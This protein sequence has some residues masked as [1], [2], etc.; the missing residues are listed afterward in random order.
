MGKIDPGPGSVVLVVGASSGIGRACAER[1]HRIGYRVYGTSRRASSPGAGVGQTSGGYAGGMEMIPMDVDDEDSVTLGVGYV[2]EKEGRLDAVV[3]SAGFAL[4][5]AV[6]DTT[7]EEAKSQF[8]TNF[9]GA[10]R[11]CRTVLPV[12]RKQ[13]HG[14][15]VIIGSAAGVVSLPFQGIYSSSKFA[16]EGLAEAL[17]IEAA[18]FG[19]RVVIAEPTDFRT[20]ITASRRMAAAAAVGDSPY[21]DLFATALAVTESGESHGPPPDRIARLIEKILEKPTPRLRYPVGP[22]SRITVLLKRLL[23]SKIYERIIIKH[24]RL[25]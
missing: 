5:G 3:N 12:M 25:L 4:A 16:L 20:G 21:G 9:F 15:I 22:L 14:Y 13:G 17:R 6:E 1:L 19:I 7:V 10:L 18:P 23:P 8:E 24:F 2:I 11:L